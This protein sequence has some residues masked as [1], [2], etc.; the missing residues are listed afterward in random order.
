MQILDFHAHLLPPAY[1]SALEKHGRLL[2]DGFPTPDWDAAAHVAMMDRAGI[3]TSLISVS[4]PHPWFGDGAGAAELSRRCNEEAA[5]LEAKYP[6]RFR[7]AALLP[8]PD[9]ERALAEAAY[10]FDVLGAAAVKLP[11]NAG[12][13][14]PGDPRLEPLFAELDRRRAI[15]IF[16]PTRPPALPEGCFTGKLLPLFE[17]LGDTTRC[18]VN[19]I[20]TGTLDRYPHVRIV[21]PHC[22]SFLPVIA[23]RLAGITALLASKGLCEPVDAAAALGRLYYDV[24]G[25]P[26]PHGLDML[27]TIAAPD[28]ILYGSDY[29]YTPAPEILGK[30]EQCRAAWDEARQRRI[31]RDNALALLS[32]GTR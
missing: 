13:I 8:V 25:N 19:L 9:V 17:F 26:L 2:E 28:H 16:H 7:S 3:E 10:A 24:A 12:G 30:L 15:V 1:V 14:Y 31:F 32:G 18:V 5:E 6:G 4:S 29:P 21:V 20:T 27:E 23:D 22:G 11:T